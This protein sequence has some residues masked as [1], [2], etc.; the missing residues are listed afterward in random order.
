[1]LADFYVEESF[2]GEVLAVEGLL[3]VFHCTVCA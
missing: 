2:A 3:E 1:V